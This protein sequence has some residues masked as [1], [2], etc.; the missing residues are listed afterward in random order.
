MAG[1]TG[2]TDP[3]KELHAPPPLLLQS[4]LCP[5]CHEA[6]RDD[7]DDWVCE[8]CNAE[9]PLGG[10][11]NQAGQ[12]IEADIYACQSMAKHKPGTVA[13]DGALNDGDDYWAWQC[14]KP[15]GHAGEHHSTTGAT[16][17]NSWLI[18]SDAPTEVTA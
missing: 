3:R 2:L 1:A 12:W 5:F 6:V 8:P 14:A 11:G 9:W 15:L 7:G 16:W 17:P 4:P 18:Q 10:A 13:V